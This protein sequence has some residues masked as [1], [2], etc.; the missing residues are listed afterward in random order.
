VKTCTVLLNIYSDIA[1]WLTISLMSDAV[2][3]TDLRRSLWRS[4]IME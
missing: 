2:G 3:L 4:R 1:M